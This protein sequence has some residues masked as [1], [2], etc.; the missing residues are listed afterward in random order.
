MLKDFSVL[1]Q[2]FKS[3]SK[4]EER[5]KV[6]IFTIVLAGFVFY[7]WFMGKVFSRLVL[8]LDSSTPY[9][10]YLK[11][12]VKREPVKGD[13]V[14]VRGK[15]GTFAEGKLVTKRG[16]CTDKEYL[17]KSGMFYYCCKDAE[18]KRCSLMHVAM[19]RTPKGKRLKLFNPCS[20]M[21]VVNGTSE[22]TNDDVYSK[23]IV[24][25]PEGFVYLG[26]SV[27]TGYDS[28]YVGF[29]KKDE[30]LWIVKPVF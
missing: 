1:I 15:T 3:L 17:K 12:E 21:E 29:W 2:R 14:V 8:T 20:S 28:R 27:P 9:H 11:E 22:W 6:L 10:L 18:G 26:T 19:D 25:I 7:L 5:R 13:Y 16:L 4:G 24:K 30:V 23:C